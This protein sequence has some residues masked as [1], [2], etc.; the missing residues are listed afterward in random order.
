M[1]RSVP[2]V[3]AMFGLACAVP[4][5]QGHSDDPKLR[6][7][8]PRYPGPGCRNCPAL[9]QR[10]AS[11]N[12]PSFVASGIALRSWVTLPELDQYFQEP[13]DNGN[14]CWGYVSGTGREYA[15]MGT[16]SGLAVVEI[17]DPGDPQVIGALDGPVSLW[18]DIKVYQDHAYVVSE[19]GSGIQVVDLSDV[20]A[21]VVAEVGT[22]L[23]GG[24]QSTHNVV[25]NEDSGYLYR[26]GGG[27]NIGLRI[28]D[29]ADPG[30]PLWVAEWQDR[31]VHDAQ[32]VS[33]TSGPY[34]GREIA[35]CCA[36]FNNGGSE[37]GLTILDVT[38]KDHIFTV[39]ENPDGH[40]QYA[41]NAYSH[42]GWLSPDRQYFFLNDEADETSFGL[43]TTMHIID[44]SD[45]TNPVEV[46]TY[47]NGT[48]A[49]T[50]NLYTL[51]DLVFAAN[52]RSGLRVFDV[53]R[54]LAPVEVA[55][56]DTYPPDDNPNFNG[57][58][59]SYPYFPSGTIIGSDVEK[60][61]FVWQFGQPLFDYAFPDGLPDVV[62][63]SGDAATVQIVEVA[64]EL[65][66]ETAALHYA[67]GGEYLSVPLAAAGDG[68]FTALFPPLACGSTV[69]YYF[70][71]ESTS[72]ITVRNPLSGP[73]GA[74]HALVAGSTVLVLADDMQADLGWSP[75]N[76]GAPSGDWER[77]V[78]V[79]DPGWD[80]DPESDS[81]GSGQCYLTA[82]APG[83]TDV[84]NGAVR[85][86]S[87][88]LNMS[89]GDGV[90]IS[91]DYFFNITNPDGVDRLLVEIS[92]ND[93]SGPWTEIASHDTDGDLA[94]QTH[95]IDGTALD[96][97]GVNLTATTRL[98][99]TVNDDGS[100]NIVEAGLDAFAL[101]SYLC[102]QPVTADL[103]GDAVV[104]AA[105]LAL[106]LGS[107]GP[108]PAACPADLNGDGGVDAADLAMLLGNWTA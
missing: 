70:S 93:L 81:D 23:T 80:Y 106:L 49:I 108:C 34:T 26:S 103:N 84:D 98:R 73:S 16:S 102:A 96:S 37:T 46:E 5:L 72:G 20:D 100:Q 58:W 35:F 54:P 47:S 104:D 78:P 56:F 31:Y 91:Y 61:L 39:I 36:G 60:G 97:A 94:W 95:V 55:L 66:P 13:I 52:Y 4:V 41:N 51:G 15:L 64:G 90:F 10:T 40:Y 105:D 68:L 38:D 71:A 3:A 7:R 57:L 17:T 45:L 87:P 30:Q 65:L 27:N 62:Q 67:V 42:Q 25:I 53:S 2:I 79:N 24:T 8:Q 75:Q 92:S 29:L 18:R 107:W 59:S 77:G 28:Y 12:L 83:N 22:V 32:V 21:G 11:G 86:T 76:L 69:E 48:T 1:K 85:L 99:F 43:N 6:D 82:N 89:N 88:Q 44:V 101:R 50:H 33:Y 74:Y 14:D 63:P 9:G 19:G